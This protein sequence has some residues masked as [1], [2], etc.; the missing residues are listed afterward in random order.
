MMFF[1]K[2]N[3]I[4]K[5]KSKKY[6]IKFNKYNYVLTFHPDKENNKKIIRRYLKALKVL[7]KHQYLFVGLIMIQAIK[8]F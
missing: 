5:K 6:N 8:K 4:I 2:K 7:K 3:F 1:Q